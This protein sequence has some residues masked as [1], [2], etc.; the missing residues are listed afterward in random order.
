M[1]RELDGIQHL[2]ASLFLCAR[3]HVCW[4]NCPLSYWLHQ[5]L[6]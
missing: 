4:Y 1:Y 5:N 3:V 6:V 2:Q